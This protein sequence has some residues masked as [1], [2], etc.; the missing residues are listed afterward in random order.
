LAPSDHELSRDPIV[1]GRVTLWQP[2][3]GYRFSVDPILLAD[4]VGTAPLGRVADI[5]AGVGIVGLLLGASDPDARVTLIELQPRM[6]ALSRRNA[7][8]NGLG[9]RTQVVQGDVRAPAMRQVLPGAS[10]DLVASCPPYYPL[11]Q[12]GV[13][14]QGEEA[15]ARHE[16]H[17]PLADLV[18]A[19][20]RLLR[21]RGRFAVVY[22]TPRLTELMAVM[23]AEGLTPVRLRI[24]HPYA[25][26]PGQRVLVE[27]RKG[28]KSSL[29]INPP[30][31]LRT[32]ATPSQGGGG[33]Y[34][35]EARRILGDVSVAT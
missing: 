1:R 8:E 9:E 4:F 7:Q 33:D 15:I 29:V 5:G 19:A 24:V 17:L 3:V 32:R 26:E 10:F 34:T 30:L 35:E 23:Q 22:P 13:N 11:G 31:Y 21:F 27:G 12:G 25:D 14:P 28:S 2:R 20:R 6:A 16:V 18:R